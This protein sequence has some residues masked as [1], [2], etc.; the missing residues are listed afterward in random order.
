M[1][2]TIYSILVLVY[3]AF[4]TPWL[5]INGRKIIHLSSIATSLNE[6]APPVVIIIAVRNEEY[7]LR[8]ALTSVCN[9]DYR[10]YKVLVINDR[11]TDNT[12]NILLEMK[13][14]Y[15]HLSVI[16]VETLPAGW[17]GKNHALYT[18][19]KSSQEEYILF[20][21]ADVVYHKDVL[22]KAMHC[23][24]KNDLDHLTILPG[25]IS[26]SSRLNSI[27][28]TFVI[29]LTALQRP[30]AAKIK[31]SKASIGV[32]AFNL[33]RREMYER[34]GTHT[35]IAMRPD[36][37]LRLAASIKAAGGKGDV[38]YGR[39]EIEVEWYT[40]VKEFI[41]GLMKN[42]FSG[43]KYNA[44]LAAGGALG[45]LLFF[46]LPIPLVLVFGNTAARILVI[47]MFLFQLILYGNMPGSN[48][49]WWYALLSIYA[50][51]IM[52]YIIVKATIT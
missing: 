3:W 30:W 22:N 19:S 25:I 31:K 35:A 1:L 24:V 41:N 47:C 6:R 21:D 4:L 36:D 52:V 8:E 14:Q 37:D 13:A 49:K 29:M 5:I 10:N 15:N 18:G 44:F 48:G 45:T 46:V 2:L 32:G 20:T 40:S 42:I 28:M 43:F 12:G 17:L 50:G 7:A 51:I 9:L 27:V 39:G 34:A 11:S 16:N 23:C 33:V 26:P 38:L